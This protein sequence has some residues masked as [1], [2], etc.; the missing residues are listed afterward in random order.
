MPPCTWFLNFARDAAGSR[1][2]VKSGMSNDPK[3]LGSDLRGPIV[4]E[5][6]PN[7][8]MHEWNFGAM[9]EAIQK[10]KGECVISMNEISRCKRL[11]LLP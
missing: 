6:L 10:S 4:S 11:V 3:V 8:M 1:S 5:R 7:C 2:P 9:K